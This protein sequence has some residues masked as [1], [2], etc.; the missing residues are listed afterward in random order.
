MTATTEAKRDPSGNLVVDERTF[1]LQ[2][3]IALTEREFPGVP[4]DK[5][6]FPQP[7]YRNEWND[8]LLAEYL[9]HEFQNLPDCFQ[10]SMCPLVTLAQVLLQVQSLPSADPKKVRFLWDKQGFHI[11]VDK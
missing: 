6:Y 11:H 10:T 7:D 3:I 2:D 5:I 1:S 8:L 9:P 4:Y